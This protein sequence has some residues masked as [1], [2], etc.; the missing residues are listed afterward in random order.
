MG[1]YRSFNQLDQ[2]QV[3]FINE[4]TRSNPNN[5][6]VKGFAG[7]GKTLVLAHVVEKV[8]A[9]NDGVS[10]CFISFTHALKDLIRVGIN[11]RAAEK[12]NFATSRGFV[13]K[14]KRYDFIFLDEV[15][16]IELEELK[17]IKNHAGKLIVAGDGDQRIYGN[18]AS[19][20]EIESTLRPKNW[21]LLLIYRLSEKLKKFALQ[22][23][24][25][26]RLVEGQR[27]VNSVD[28][29]IR[30]VSFKSSGFEAGWVWSEAYRD[31][32]P[33]EPAVIL[34]CSHDDVFEFATHLSVNLSISAPPRPRTKYKNGPLDYSEFNTFWVDKGVDLMFFGSANGDISLSSKRPIVYLMTIYSAKGLDFNS[35]YIPKMANGATLVPKAKWIAHDPSIERKVLFVAA[36][37]SREKLTISYA[38]SMGHKFLSELSGGAKL[39][40]DPKTRAQNDEEEFF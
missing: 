7:S 24:P 16:D 26:R 22:I 34:F 9:G 17:V 29:D 10:V 21:Q 25:S 37:R 15:Q 14:P 3:Q 36:T 5:H 19:D 2:R 13:K 27:A 12:V 32:K 18:G 23:Y 33:G 38:G 35:V 1:W 39:I 40:I 6:W 30:I 8:V 11:S 31:A 4:I 20:L 28:T